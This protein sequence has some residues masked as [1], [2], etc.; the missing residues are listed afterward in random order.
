MVWDSDATTPGKKHKAVLLYG[1]SE[2][3]AFVSTVYSSSV[4]LH[5]EYCVYTRFH[6]FS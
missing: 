6:L 5:S 4:C 1:F 3:N 2:V